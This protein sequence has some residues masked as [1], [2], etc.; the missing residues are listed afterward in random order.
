MS[1]KPKSLAHP[2]RLALLAGSLV[3]LSGCVTANTLAQI[4]LRTDRIAAFERAVSNGDELIVHYRVNTYAG[5]STTMMGREVASGLAKWSRVDL[6]TVAWAPLTVGAGGAPAEVR[7]TIEDGPAPT[8]GAGYAEVPILTIPL[9]YWVD[10]GLRIR[11]RAE[12]VPRLLSTAESHP[13]SL[14][15]YEHRLGPAETFSVLVR[16]DATGRLVHNDR[17]RPLQRDYQAWWAIPARVAAAPLVLIV[18]VLLVSPLFLL[19]R[20]L[21]CHLHI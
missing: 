12:M 5:T 17:V 3:L 21:D 19:C 7:L 15:Q 18:D 11:T 10:S 2:F 6:R 14:H 16:R 4:G 20:A 9:A 13:L 1:Q 8:L